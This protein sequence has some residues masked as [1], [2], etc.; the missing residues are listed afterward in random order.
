MK[1]IYK[2]LYL[3]AV[4]IFAALLQNVVH[5]GVHF[6]SARLFGEQVLEFRLFTNGWGSSQVVYATPVAQRTGAHWL[7]IAWLPAVVTVLI[8]F[9]IYAFRNKLLTKSPVVNLVVWY[10][11]VMFMVID[12]LY[13]G[14]LSWFMQGSDVNAAEIMGWPVWPFRIL[15]LAVLAIGIV[16]TLR[17][18][19]ES[20]EH[21]EDYQLKAFSAEAAE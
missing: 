7:L 3:Y 9:L 10:L 13:F 4:L 14:V 5:E 19:T 17:W 11:G 2:R 12:P 1:S 6:V 18:R 8:G 20:R 21:V 16:I 15:G